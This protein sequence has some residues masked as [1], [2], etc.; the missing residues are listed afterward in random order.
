MRCSKPAAR[1]RDAL[2]AL[3]E[4]IFCCSLRSPWNKLVESDNFFMVPAIKSFG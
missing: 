3:F 4:R 1:G 2:L